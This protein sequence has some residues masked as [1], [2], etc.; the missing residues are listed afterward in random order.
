MAF[1]WSNFSKTVLRQVMNVKSNENLSLM[2]ALAYLLLRY[3]N[4]A[5]YNSFYF[6]VKLIFRSHA[7]LGHINDAREDQCATRPRHRLQHAVN[8]SRS[9]FQQKSKIN[10]PHF[11]VTF[12][13]L[14][15]TNVQQCYVIKKQKVSLENWSKLRCRNNSTKPEERFWLRGLGKMAGGRDRFPMA[16]LDRR[17]CP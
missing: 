12:L 3:L 7:L 17:G 13:Q 5:S 6:F 11:R 15:S 4:R 9:F 14:Y 10:I 8:E 2:A 16:G 1:N